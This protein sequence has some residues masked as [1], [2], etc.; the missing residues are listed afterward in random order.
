[1]NINLINDNNNVTFEMIKNRITKFNKDL[2]NYKNQLDIKINMI[3]S[4]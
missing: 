4:N 1:M 3:I 2:E